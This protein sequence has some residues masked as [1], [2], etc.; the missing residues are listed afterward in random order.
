[1][2][3]DKIITFFITL[4]HHINYTNM[5]M[6]F[7]VL[8]L[9]L[10][11][12]SCTGNDSRQSLR[13][14]ESYISNKPQMA[15]EKLDSLSKTGVKGSQ[16]NAKFALLYSMALDKNA[17]DI[18][19][20]SLINI[21]VKWYE[22]HGN[23]DE[24]LKAY[25]Y[26]GRVF[27]N[28]E[29]DE[30]A[31]LSF[32]KADKYTR[33]AKDNVAAG[34]LYLAMA[35]ISMSILDTDSAL[36][37]SEK[38]SLRFSVANDTIRH[39][40]SLLKLATNYSINGNYQKVHSIL[41]S[42]SK[43]MDFLPPS[44]QAT[45]YNNYIGLALEQSEF[46]KARELLE[47]YLSTVPESSVS[48]LCVSKS[49]LTLGETQKSLEALGYYEKYN[50]DYS[51]NPMYYSSV[52]DTYDSLKDYKTA[53]WAYKRY[54][55]IVDTLNMSIVSDDTKFI[56]EK[57]ENSL[58]ITKER[59]SKN[60]ASLLVLA[61]SIVLCGVFYI[62]RI[63]KR[64]HEMEKKTYMTNY[65]KLEEERMELED[66]LSKN[67]IMDSRLLEVVNDRL[68]LLDKFIAAEIS[69]NNEIDA[70]AGEEL[71]ELIENR[72]SFLTTTR[73]AFAAAHP[74]FVTFLEDK[75]LTDLQIEYCCL[76]AIGL[77]GKE[78]A[79]YTNNKRHYIDI[80]DVREK[81]GLKTQR[82]TL[83]KYLKSLLSES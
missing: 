39:A 53:L 2:N 63:I 37:Y 25:Y 17:I 38:A 30:T 26:Q 49:Y 55:S 78:I 64:K 8:L 79:S 61:L 7:R 1:M 65:E 82:I 12:A 80:L 40:I 58:Q 24:R 4:S 66:M 35:N 45:F 19:D 20:D 56:K 77:K 70:K 36:E 23:A 50:P 18:T 69:G 52:S 3:Q 13:S 73:M 21:A 54:Q 16:D 5:K 34:L 83:G 27:Q 32:A 10:M 43:T 48:W 47:E 57:Y 67:R 42:L 75:G 29:D 6:I 59:N 41:D 9:I 33:K 62:V 72:T 76:Y 44:N 51:H 28:A 22:R 46:L 71:R 11:L 31:M 14:I 15:L 68:V 60:V 74:R 81:L